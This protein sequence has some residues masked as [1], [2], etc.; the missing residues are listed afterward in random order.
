MSTSRN[1]HTS[2]KKTMKNRNSSSNSSNLTSMFRSV[3]SEKITGIPIIIDPEQNFF[4]YEL[5]ENKRMYINKCFKILSGTSNR[6]R[7]KTL[8]QLIDINV[9]S[10]TF[11]RDRKKRIPRKFILTFEKNGKLSTISLFR[12]QNLLLVD[13]GLIMK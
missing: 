9:T 10:K 2:S 11:S 8:G 7:Y 6:M 1:S 5:F 12:N 4:A 13:C 3:S